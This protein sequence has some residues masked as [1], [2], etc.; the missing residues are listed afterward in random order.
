MKMISDISKRQRWLKKMPEMS[1]K[2]L[3]NGNSPKCSPF[4]RVRLTVYQRDTQPEMDS[5]IWFQKESISQVSVHEAR[6]YPKQTQPMF[7]N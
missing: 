4:C 5:N 2:G 7:F 1:A 6:G 3:A